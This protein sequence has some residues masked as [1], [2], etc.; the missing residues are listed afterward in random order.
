MPQNKKKWSFNSIQAWIAGL[1]GVLLVTSSLI[2]SAVGIYDSIQGIPSS[3]GERGN[4]ELY[5]K[6]FNSEPLFKGNVPINTNHG[7]IHLVLEVHNGG[8][9]LVKY[10]I[11]SQWFP[12]PSNVANNE[13]SFISSAV[14]DQVMESPEIGRKYWKHEEYVGKSIQ[15]ELYYD[16]GVKETYIIETNTGLWSKPTRTSYEEL[17]QAIS[18]EIDVFSFPEI[19]IRDK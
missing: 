7:K 12:Y 1:T 4:I 13:F 11:R 16:D 2:H 17:P 18:L 5:E 8:D 9:I 6:Y 15:R 19:D 14:A 3:I 10:G